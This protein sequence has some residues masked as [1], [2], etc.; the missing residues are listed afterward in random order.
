MST[1][2]QFEAWKRTVPPVH[3]E[4]VEKMFRA[5]QASRAAALEEALRAVE[6]ERLED[7]SKNPDDIAYDMAVDDCAT[8]IRKLAKG[9]A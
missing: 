4:E 7:P 9:N 6:A 2:E 1:R 8:A 5:W 3:A